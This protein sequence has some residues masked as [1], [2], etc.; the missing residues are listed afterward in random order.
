MRRQFLALTAVCSLG[1]FALA[2]PDPAG[3]PGTRAE[4]VRVVTA[5]ICEEDRDG[6]PVTFVCRGGFPEG[7]EHLLRRMLSPLPGTL[8]VPVAL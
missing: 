5:M 8:E 7:M 4:V 1:G 3:T 2:T 6:R